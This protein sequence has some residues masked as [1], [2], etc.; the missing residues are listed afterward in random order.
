MKR[1]GAAPMLLP[2]RLDRD[3]PAEGPA[4]SPFSNMAETGMMCSVRLHQ[5]ELVKLFIMGNRSGGD[6]QHE[7]KGSFVLEF[8][9][10]SF[11]MDF[12]VLDYANPVTDMLKQAQRHTMLTPWSDDARP[13]PANPIF[14]DI[15]PI[16]SGDAT[17]FHA[18]MDAT[19]GWEGW[20]SKWQ[21]TWDSPTPETFVI[22]DEWVVAKGRGVEFH[23]TT[24][25]PMRRAGDRIIIEGSRARA[26]LLIPAGVE[27]VLEEL[28]LLD[29]RRRS[30]DTVYHGASNRRLESVAA[31][32]HGSLFGWN[33]APTQPRLTL[34]QPGRSGTLRVE[35]KLVL[36]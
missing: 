26:E 11:A 23:W 31:Q 20:F 4:L 28:A 34:R 9:G 5:G 13:H 30:V 27:V 18:T 36:K 2:L 17:R 29:P 25:L 15:R 3:I 1:A 33:H 32:K 22:T 35:V 8:A 21:R 24:R 7:D 16:G 12:G 19:P 6:H 10:D 14:A